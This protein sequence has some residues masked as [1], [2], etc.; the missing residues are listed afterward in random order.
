MIDRPE[1]DKLVAYLDALYPRYT[2]SA[3]AIEVYYDMLGDLPVW[4]AEGETSCQIRLMLNAEKIILVILTG[5]ARR[6]RSSCWSERRQ[7]GSM[8]L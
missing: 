4:L 1:F 6:C 5:L 2:L 7:D 8:R 3:A